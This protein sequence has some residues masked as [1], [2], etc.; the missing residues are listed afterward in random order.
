VGGKRKTRGKRLADKFPLA[1]A[2]KL[3]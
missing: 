1:R 3:S 2:A